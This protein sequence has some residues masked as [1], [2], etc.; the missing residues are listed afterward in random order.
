MTHRLYDLSQM[1]REQLEEIASGLK[2][3]S[4]KKLDDE[5]L[6]YSILD[7][8]AN[9]AASQPDPVKSEPKKRGRKPKAEK[10]QEQPK[11]EEPK[12]EEAA[13]VAEPEQEKPAPKKRGRKPKA[14][15]PQAEEPKE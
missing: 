8:E 11:P 4:I 10:A 14:Q 3:K 1:S 5:N 12:K 2:I 6:A 7:A 9:L 15:K 13:P